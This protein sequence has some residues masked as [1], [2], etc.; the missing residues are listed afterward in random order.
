MCV[1]DPSRAASP[2]YIFP[3]GE[4]G[5]LIPTSD[6]PS[7]PTQSRCCFNWGRVTPPGLEY[8]VNCARAWSELGPRFGRRFGPKRPGSMTLSYD[9][10]IVPKWARVRVGRCGWHLLVPKCIWVPTSATLIASRGHRCPPPRRR[11]GGAGSTK[12]H[13]CPR[14]PPLPRGQWENADYP[15]FAAT[16]KA[17]VGGGIPS[18][19]PSF[20]AA[21]Y[22]R[23]CAGLAGVPIWL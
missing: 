22:I 7:R 9:A 12:K 13:F 18:F 3:T 17:K 19:L 6:T 15:L 23:L 14:A 8:P 21:T 11:G 4:G 16:R 5:A 10:W 2:R 20:R 1:C